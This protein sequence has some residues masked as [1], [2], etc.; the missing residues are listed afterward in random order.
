MQI[1][2][3][4]AAD[5]QEVADVHVRAWQIGYQGMLPRSYLDRLNAADRAG[6]YTFDAMPLDGP[7]TLV[8]TDQSGIGGLVTIGR[9]RDADLLD[10][11]EIWALYS[12][13]DRWGTGIGRELIAAARELLHRNGYAEAALWVL[14]CNA[15]ARR[16]YEIDG[17]HWDGT[18]R[19]DEIGE[20]PVEDV[21]Y[22]R[23]LT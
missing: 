21:R 4:V 17:W 1:R 5:A 22:R 3:A 6:R 14:E 19:T 7:Y 15:R 20:V 23:S 10:H 9:C 18:H 12:D 8:A 2:P 11:G 13:P 16:F